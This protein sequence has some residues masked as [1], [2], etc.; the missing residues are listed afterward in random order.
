MNRFQQH[1]RDSILFGYSCFDRMILK[2][3]IVPFNHSER[4]GTIRWFLRTHRQVESSRAAFA[5]I[6]RDYHDWVYR[7]AQQNAI[8][9]VEPEKG[10]SREA[11]VEPYFRQ[12]GQHTGIAVI[13]K[14]REPERVA[15][16]YVKTNW[17]GVERRNIDLYYF[18]LNDAQCGRM[19]LRICPYFPCNIGV[20]L[21]GHNWLSCKLRQE[22]IAFETRDNL[23]VSCA[24]PERLQELSDA[25]APTDIVAT[26]ETWLARLLPFFSDAERQQGYTD[27]NGNF[28]IWLPVGSYYLVVNNPSYTEPVTEVSVT[29][30]TPATPSIAMLANVATL[31]G[32][33]YLDTNGD[34]TFDAGDTPQANDVIVISSGTVTV[35]AVTDSMGNYLVSLPVGT[36]SVFS[37]APNYTDP[38]T[39]ITLATAGDSL[40]Q[41]VPMELNQIQTTVVNGTADSFSISDIAVSGGTATVTTTLPNDFQSGQQVQI[42]GTGTSDD[43][44]WT[45]LSASGNTFT[46]SDSG[47]VRAFGGAADEISWAIA[48]ASENSSNVVTITTTSQSGLY[49]GQLVDITN[50]GTGY[51]GTYTITG[52]SAD[53]FTYSVGSSVTGLS[54]ITPASSAGATATAALA[55]PQRS[56]V[57]SI[58]ITFAQQVNLTAGA[59]SISVIENNTITGSEVG[60]APTLNVPAV[61]GTDSWVVTFTDPVNNSVMATRLPTGRI[62]LRST[63]RW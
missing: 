55:G 26:V 59:L 25:F 13:L 23:F 18:Y 8:E 15:C 47:A 6:S 56:M 36:Y 54:P 38:A 51:N 21:N 5:K 1:H 50:V 12:L 57:D 27:T 19:F 31:S 58:V 60:V 39:P 49:V 52:T 40:T 35:T 43:G 14:A 11:L 7:Y 17:V 20:W 63:Q 3:S 42:V 30:G 28:S 32:Q 16:H 46:F 62:P 9:I 53:A 44:V 34:N 24:R 41:N 33:V 10:I 45:I 29:A 4:G 2:G 22:G 48:S 61:P 37:M